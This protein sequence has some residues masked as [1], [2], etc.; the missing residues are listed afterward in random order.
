MSKV[1]CKKRKPTNWKSFLLF[2]VF[3]R[4]C[5][6]K[7]RRYCW[8]FSGMFCTAYSISSSR[9]PSAIKTEKHSWYEPFYSNRPHPNGDCGR[10]LP[11]TG[12]EAVPCN[13]QWVSSAQQKSVP[14]LELLVLINRN[15]QQSKS[16]VPSG[17]VWL[18]LVIKSGPVKPHAGLK[19]KEDVSSVLVVKDTVFQSWR[20]RK[21]LLSLILGILG[22]A[23]R[24]H[25]KSTVFLCFICLY[26]FL[27][28]LLYA[29]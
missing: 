11:K 14:S 28:I 27:N 18:R 3:F 8:Q 25:C 19:S 4:K 21:R 22:S 20:R 17:H 23:F 2:S 24:E 7:T 29:I 12:S 15:F 10:Y 1:A 9:K 5:Q 13:S 26:L 6:K 16:Q